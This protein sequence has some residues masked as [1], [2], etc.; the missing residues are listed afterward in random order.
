M[1]WRCWISS[2][3]IRVREPVTHPDAIV[4]LDATLLHHVDVFGGLADDGSVVV[5]S[6]HTAGELA[7]S[8]PSATTFGRA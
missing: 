5:N 2:A 4:I 8:A 3:L 6:V 7:P 1:N